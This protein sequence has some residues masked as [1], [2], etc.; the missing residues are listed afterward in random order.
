MSYSSIVTC[1]TL[2]QMKA[3]APTGSYILCLLGN[4][5]PAVESLRFYDFDFASTASADDNLVV[6]TNVS[7]YSTMGRWLKVDFDVAP[8]VNA[9]WTASSGPSMVLNKPTL[10]T[11]A[12]SGSYNDLS[13]TPT[14]PAAY[15]FSVSS[16][17]SRTV[18][19]ATAY[20]ASTTTKPAEVTINLT[21]TA[22]LSLSGGTTDE[23]DIIIGSTSAVASGMGTVIGKFKNSLT[24]TLVVGLAVNNAQTCQFKFSLP[25]GWY[26]A[27]RQITGTGVSVVS[28]FDQVLG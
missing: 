14:I 23:A 12:V 3:E 8:Q 26:F 15:S 7:G 20:Q 24:G 11:V 6:A 16:P 1:A 9:D 25:I 27:V 18:A 19:L 17:T 4:D 10:A 2:S 22:A 28:A 5:Y 21:S 13:N